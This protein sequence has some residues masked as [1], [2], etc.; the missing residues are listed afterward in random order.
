V[1]RP[2]RVSVPTGAAGVRS[3][4]GDAARGDPRVVNR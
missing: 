4:A 1:A 2:P 3:C